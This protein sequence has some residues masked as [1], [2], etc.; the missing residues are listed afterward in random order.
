MAV[1]LSF[2]LSKSNFGRTIYWVGGNR[3]AAERVGIN[4]FRNT[5]LVYGIAGAI[6][7]I[8]SIAC[9]YCT[10]GYS[11]FNCRN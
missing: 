8:G 11:K 9:S 10:D 6:F 1:I 3:R 4:T 5:M 7:G 2:V